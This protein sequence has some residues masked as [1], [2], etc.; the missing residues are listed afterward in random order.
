MYA[1]LNFCN[2]GSTQ[3]N[4][5][6]LSGIV[7]VVKSGL[8]VYLLCSDMVLGGGRTMFCGGPGVMGAPGAG[9]PLVVGCTGPAAQAADIL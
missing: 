2:L 6:I 8:V 7:I 9:L 3:I 5:E 4:T 1:T